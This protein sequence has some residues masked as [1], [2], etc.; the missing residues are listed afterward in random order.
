[1]ERKLVLYISM[2]LDGF[3]ATKDNKLDF[4]SIVEQ[5][6]EDYGYFEFLKTVDTIIIGRKTYDK[7]IEMGYK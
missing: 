6:N 5:K 2:S 3:I 4:L 1:M 7:V